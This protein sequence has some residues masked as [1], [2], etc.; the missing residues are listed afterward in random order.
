MTRWLASGVLAVIAAAMAFLVIDA[1]LGVL[2]PQVPII[3]LDTRLGTLLRPNLSVRKAFGGHERVVTVTTNTFGLRGA[4]LPAAKPAGTRRILALGDSFTFGDA[5]QMEETWPQQLEA[6]LNGGGVARPY[7][8]VNAGVGGYGTAHAILLSSILVPSVQPD[9][10]VL[11][12]SVVNDILDNLCVDEASY[13]PRGNAPCFRLDGDRLVLAEPAPLDRPRPPSRTWGT[14][15]SRAAEFFW[16]QLR[17]LTLWNPHVL[18]VARRLGVRLELPYMPAT[19]ASWY[20]ERYSERGWALTRRLLVELHDRL[21]A[22]SVPLMVLIIPGSVQAEGADGAKKAIL[23]SLGGEQRAIR[24]FLEDPTKPQGLITRFCVEARIE[25]VDPLPSLLDVER[26]G[27]HA[28]YPLDQ[29]WT[30]DAH[31]VAADAIAAHLRRIGW[32]EAVR[33][34]TD[35]SCPTCR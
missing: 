17:R 27:Q 35:A 28:Y 15:G 26:K 6:R 21:T 25:C 4:E 1:G 5:V 11:G 29:H 12:F 7:E 18:D 13:G 23:R 20:D 19:I 33:T 9:L 31:G 22:R 14:P 16:G 2:Y 8:V 3:T 34:V 10:V 24:A 32:T 30:P